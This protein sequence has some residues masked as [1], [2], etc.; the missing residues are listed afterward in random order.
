MGCVIRSVIDIG[1]TLCY[2]AV[3]VSLE[4]VRNANDYA[5]RRRV[6]VEVCVGI[7]LVE[8]R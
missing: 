7:A 1:R 3:N 4:H 5:P 6:P 2:R 8:Q